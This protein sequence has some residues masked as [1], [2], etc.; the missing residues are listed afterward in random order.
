MRGREIGEFD[1]E[2][3]RYLEEESDYRLK[4]KLILRHEPLQAGRDAQVL[5]NDKLVLQGMIKLSL[6]HLVGEII[7]P[8]AG[9]I[10]LLLCNG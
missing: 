3:M 2:L 5:L 1:I 4:A 7:D 8:E 10:C 9:Q 6:N